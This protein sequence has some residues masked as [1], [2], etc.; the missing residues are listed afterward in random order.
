MFYKLGLEFFNGSITTLATD[1]FTAATTFTK[2]VLQSIHL[3]NDAEPLRFQLAL[4]QESIR[5][6]NVLARFSLLHWSK[7]GPQEPC[8]LAQYSFSVSWLSSYSSS[9][10]P[11]VRS[12]SP[13]LFNLKPHPSP[14]GKMKPAGATKPHYGDWNPNLVR[15]LY[16]IGTSK[17]IN[18]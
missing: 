13:R 6:L 16:R 9:I 3:F 14:G 2:R 1:R 10:A 8:S 12:L 4:L 7:N 17:P 18:K 11:P 15:I 5:P